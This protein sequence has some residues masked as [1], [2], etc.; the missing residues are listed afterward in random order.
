MAARPLKEMPA[1]LKEVYSYSHC[2][3]L[4]KISTGNPFPAAIRFA[5]ARAL[6]SLHAGVFG[7]PK[8]AAL[9]SVPTAPL[10]ASQR[11]E[12]AAWRA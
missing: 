12:L 9:R 6:A 4:V 10:C 8:A 1:L 3:R 2:S 7:A 11:R 5:P